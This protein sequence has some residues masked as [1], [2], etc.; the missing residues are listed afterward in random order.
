MLVRNSAH[1]K[2]LDEP[3]ISYLIWRNI[4][5]KAAVVAADE[6][7]AGTRAYLNFG[8]TL[9][10][11]IEAAD[12]QLLHGE[13]VA[14]GMRAASEVGVLC[15]TCGRDQAQRIGR[16]IDEFELPTNA[17]FNESVVVARLGSDKKRV[18]GRQRYVL[19]IDGGGVTIRDNVSD[20]SVWQALA[21]V[22]QETFR[23]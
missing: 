14:L 18:A 12:Y 4:S 15:G 11:A 19:P 5:L 2:R 1:L 22:N 17:R 6:R 21:T 16:L 20:Q 23:S 13:A 8:H 10:H 7:E 3:S 9:G